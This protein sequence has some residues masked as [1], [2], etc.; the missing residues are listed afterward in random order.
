MAKMG[1]RIRAVAKMTGISLDTLR[2]RERRYQAVKPQRGERRRLYRDADVHRLL[3]LKDLVARGH[4]IG[5]IASLTDSTLEQ[6]FRS[7]AMH[8]RGEDKGTAAD[9]VPE[10][11]QPLLRSVVEFDT[12]GLDRELGKL[13]LAFPPRA[14]MYVVIHPLL[15]RTGWLWL[16]G[17]EMLEKQLARIGARF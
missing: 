5:Q 14:L 12:A 9:T 6:L 13:A 2:A 15:R 11:L 16:P 8:T 3:L 7:T 17:F 10:V 1:Y 4:A